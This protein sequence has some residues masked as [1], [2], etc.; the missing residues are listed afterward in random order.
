MT[1]SFKYVI[2]QYIITK[3]LKTS[4]RIF[5]Y[6]CLST[7]TIQFLGRPGIQILLCIG[8]R[9]E[10]FLVPPKMTGCSWSYLPYTYCTILPMTPLFW[11]QINVE[12][13]KNNQ[14]FSQYFGPV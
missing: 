1:F 7:V 11:W 4:G 3:N 6:N 2:D 10:I 5:W 13:P 8:S 14:D 9:F 12:E